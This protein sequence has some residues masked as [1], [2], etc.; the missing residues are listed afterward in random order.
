MSVSLEK[1][2]ESGGDKRILK[3]IEKRTLDSNASGAVHL[4]RHLI[5]SVV[6]IFPLESLFPF[7]FPVFSTNFAKPKSA[8]F[9][10]LSSAMST[11]L[12]ATSRWTI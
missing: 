4:V 7:S 12:A 2:N 6:I 11:L 10:V 1:K 9:A 3:K 5:F 8:T